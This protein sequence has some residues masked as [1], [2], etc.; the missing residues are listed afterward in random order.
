MINIL[1]KN[2]PEVIV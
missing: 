1:Q 2:K